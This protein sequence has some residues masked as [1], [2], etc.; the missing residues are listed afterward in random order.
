MP[1]ELSSFVIDGELDTLTESEYYRKGFT[2]MKFYYSD[3][4]LVDEVSQLPEMSRMPDGSY[5][6]IVEKIPDSDTYAR[7]AGPYGEEEI[8]NVS[9]QTILESLCNTLYYPPIECALASLPKNA[10]S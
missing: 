1:K 10:T 5:Q 8:R 9:S 4:S 2:I 7:I 3:N 6:L